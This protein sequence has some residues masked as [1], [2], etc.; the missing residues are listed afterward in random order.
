MAEPS[1]LKLGGMIEGM[2][3]NALAPREGIFWI[4]QPGS[5]LLGHGD[6]IKTPNLA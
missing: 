6:E 4:R 1:G 5:G 3:E 2:G